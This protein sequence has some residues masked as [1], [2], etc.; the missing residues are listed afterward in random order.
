VSNDTPLLKKIDQVIN[1]DEFTLPVFSDVALKVRNLLKNKDYAVKD[2]EKIICSDQT[3]TSEV[4]RVA[5]SPFYSGIAQVNSIQNAAVRLGGQQLADLVMIAS[6]RNRYS[7]ADKEINHFMG[8]LWKHAVGTALASQWLAKKLKYPDMVN[9]AF[10]SGLIHDI[11]ILA[12]FKATDHLKQVEN[13]QIPMDL[14][15]GIIDSTHSMYG[16][17]LAKQWNLPESYCE[18]IKEHHSDTFDQSNIPLT[19]VRLSDLCCNKIGIDIYEPAIFDLSSTP[20]AVNLG[21]NEVMVAE[22]EIMLEDTL[23]IS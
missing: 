7:A 19:I 11:G 12:I 23:N 1:S 17:K 5:N 6:E 15:L 16:Y 3:L 9:K 22:L 4:L 14:I 10:M 18:I 20:E 13:L 8:K 2:I 21:V